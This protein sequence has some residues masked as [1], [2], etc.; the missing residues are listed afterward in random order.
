VPSSALWSLFQN[1]T[2]HGV[3][4]GLSTCSATGGGY[5]G[6]TVAGGVVDGFVVYGAGV[7]EYFIF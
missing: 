6:S 3:Q 7:G 1:N 5:D 2:A 4:Q